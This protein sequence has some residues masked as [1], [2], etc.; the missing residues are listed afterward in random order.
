MPLIFLIF[1]SL[2]FIVPAAFANMAPPLAKRIDFLGR[3]V[4]FG[5]R[6]RGKRILGDHKTFRGLLFGVIAAVVAAFLQKILYEDVFFFRELSIVDYSATN[7][8]ALGFLLG[9]GA[10]FGDMVESFFK[11]RRG[12]APGKPWIPWDQMDFLLGSLLFCMVL[13][14]PPWKVIVILVILV[15][16][17]HI[18]INRI[19]YM[20]GLQKNKC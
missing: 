4:D 13:F 17:L 3:P 12:T 14:I 1:Q 11:R 16:I 7:F 8:V 5:K 20:L 6:W 15:P 2:Y 9:F 18:A 10:L 19:G